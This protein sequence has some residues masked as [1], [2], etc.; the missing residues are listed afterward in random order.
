MRAQRG[1]SYWG[2]VAFLFISFVG[3]QFFFAVGQ[4]YFDDITINKIV[5]AK[6]KAEPNNVD[7]TTLL[8]GLSQQFDL[9]GIRDVKIAD[10]F[11]VTNDGGIEIIK[12]YEIRNSFIANI[13]LV[14]HF[15][16]TFNQKAIKAAG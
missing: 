1:I 9:N 6:L 8:D 15:E 2:L 12:K 5:E 11:K 7:P 10:R 14:V 16:K 3:L 13:D 4:A